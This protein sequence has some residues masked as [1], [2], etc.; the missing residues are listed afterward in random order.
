MN[1]HRGTGGDSCTTFSGRG[2]VR[3]RGV[4]LVGLLVALLAAVPAL[5]ATPPLGLYDDL[6]GATIAAAKWQ[7]L[8]FVRE[9]RNGKLVS[10]LRA[11]GPSGDYSNT[12]LLTNPTTIQSLQADARLNAYTAPPGGT[13]RV[14]VAG[15]FYN[16]GTAGTGSTGDVAAQVFLLGNSSG[17]EIRYGAFKCTNTDCSTSIDVIQ[18]TLVNAGVLGEAHT[19]GVAWDGSVF[20]FTVDGVPTV[21]DPR[22][23]APV[24][25]APRTL[26]KKVGTRITTAGAGGEGYVAGDFENVYVNGVLYD[27]FDGAPYS[28]PHLDPTKWANLEFVQEIQGGRVVSKA[29]TAGPAGNVVRSRLHPVN[30]NAVTE[31][32]ADVTV[33]EFQASSGSV[34]AQLNGS[35]YNDGSSTGANDFTGEVEAYMQI[36]SFAGGQLIGRFHAD[37]C[38]DSQCNNSSLLS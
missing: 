30:R 1:E 2:C 38:T 7:P 26:E 8:E 18:S 29:A 11:A 14:R 12:S 9:I 25:G 31:M 5:A 22:P 33:T 32:Q 34:H 3:L 17:V 10:I 23:V 24:A 19:L 36:V 21:V 15:Y 27:N 6:S 28:G 35:F 4:W 16:D 37:R 20:T 13:V